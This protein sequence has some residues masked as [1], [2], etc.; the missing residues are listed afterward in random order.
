M[1]T[2]Q[3]ALVALHHFAGDR[4]LDLVLPDVFKQ[5]WQ[6]LGEQVCVAVWM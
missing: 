2:Q 1:A 3:G 4:Q 6:A 5:Q